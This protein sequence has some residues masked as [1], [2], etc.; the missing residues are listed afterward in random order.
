MGRKESNQTKKCT[1]FAEL[2]I[3]INI[4]YSFST[5]DLFWNKSKWMKYIWAL[6]CEKPA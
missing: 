2:F 1:G 3:E 4:V 5:F 6:I